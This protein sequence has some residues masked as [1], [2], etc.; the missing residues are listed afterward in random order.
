[1]LWGIALS[2]S[3]GQQH[4]RSIAFFLIVDILTTILLPTLLCTGFGFFAVVVDYITVGHIDLRIIIPQVMPI[5]EL[6]S[7]DKYDYWVIINTFYFPLR[8]RNDRIRH[9][10]FYSFDTSPATWF[11]V[12]IIFSAIYLTLSLF[13][14][15]TLDEQRSV[16][17]C[18]SEFIDPSFDCFSAISFEFVDC[19]NVTGERLLHCFKF[20]EFGLESNVL[21]AI[22]SA[23]AF[24]L[25]AI[26]I[27]MQMFY[28]VHDLL[29]IRPTRLWGVGFLI[30]GVILYAASI[31]TTVLW[32]TGI[33][34]GSLNLSIVHIVQIFM[35]SSFITFMGLLLLTTMWFE[36]IKSKAHAQ[37]TKV[38]LVHYTDCDKRRILEIGGMDADKWK[39]SDDDANMN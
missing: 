37:G 5:V 35:A 33:T 38:P 34:V 20:L 28:A 27:F 39:C 10:F 22:S 23:Y 24:Y 21:M 36:K 25:L 9:G 16:T 2:F 13:I 19:A 14:D 3:Y 8:K 1:M 4:Q 12:A 31:A 11:L 26:R 15:I 6:E 17:S 32:A 7:G 30:L 29:K 18:D